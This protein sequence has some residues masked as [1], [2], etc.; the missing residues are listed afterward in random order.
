MVA[1]TY[2]QTDL[3]ASH[4][5]RTGCARSTSSSGVSPHPDDLRV[6]GLNAQQKLFHRIYYPADFSTFTQPRPRTPPDHFRHAM[7][8]F[9]LL[10]R[11]ACLITASLIG[12]IVLHRIHATA[13]ANRQRLT[14]NRFTP[15]APDS[16]RRDAPGGSGFTHLNLQRI[17]IVFAVCP[18]RRS[19]YPL[20]SIISQ[21]NDNVAGVGTGSRLRN[22]S[23]RRQLAASLIA[24]SSAPCLR[25]STPA[26][27]SVP[28]TMW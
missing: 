4:P 8:V 1:V 18:S 6:I 9:L 11:S 25:P 22:T 23:P 5:Y 2:P 19:I 26:A 12:I 21:M 20:P 10:H 27:S 13:A 24:P 28:R 17:V 3:C 15:P 14:R 16:S 7:N